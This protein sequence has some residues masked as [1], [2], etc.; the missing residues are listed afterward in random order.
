MT[1]SASFR[2]RCTAVRGR[3]YTTTGWQRPGHSLVGA[4]P[5]CA[6]TTSGP[7]PRRCPSSRACGSGC[8]RGR[9]ADRTETMSWLEDF[10]AEDDDDLDETDVRDRN[11]VV[12]GKGASVRV[13]LGGR[14]INNKNI[15]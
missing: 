7:P 5:A 4:S 9:A 11:S 12:S 13:D 2:G 6:S 14:R 3:P 1:S 8:G 15:N 10:D